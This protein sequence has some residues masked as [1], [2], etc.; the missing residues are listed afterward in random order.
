MRQLY[1]PERLGPVLAGTDAGIPILRSLSASVDNRTQVTDNVSVQYGSQ[2]DMVSFLDHLT[3][4]SPYARLSWAADDATDVEVAYSSGNARPDMVDAGADDAGLR[5]DLNSL[6]MFPRLSLADGHTRL[7][8][9]EEYEVAVAHKMGSRALR[10]SAYREML[11]DAAIAIVT[12]AGF[13]MSGNIVPDL[14]SNSSV[15]NAGNFDMTG[16]DA[17]FT[18]NLGEHVSVTVSYGN[19]DE[20]I[21][22]PHLWMGDTLLTFPWIDRALFQTAVDTRAGQKFNHLRGVLLSRPDETQRAFLSADQPNVAA[23]REIDDRVRYVNSKGI[24]ADLVLAWTPDQLVK[25]FPSWQQRERYVRYLAARYSAMHITWQLSNEFENSD[26]SRELLKEI[27]QT[28]K[29]L[30]SYQHPRSTGTLATSSPLLEDGWEDYVSYGSSEDGLGAIEHQLYTVPFV[31]LRIGSEDSGAGRSGPGDGDADAF[32]RRLWNSTMDG[33][34]PTFANTGTSGAGKLPVDAKYLDSPAAR[35]MSVWSTFFAGTRYWDLEP[36]F[37]VDGGRALALERPSGDDE[38]ELGQEQ[39]QMEGV[40]YVV[41]VEKPGPVEVTIRKQTYD[42]EWVN[43][44]NGEAVTLKRFKGDK[45]SGEPPDRSHDWVLHI[46]REGRKQSLRSYKFES[47]PVIMQEIERVPQKI[48]YE[49]A[50]PSADS[51]SLSKPASYA[52]KLDAGHQG[53][54]RDDVLVDGRGAR[55]P[56]GPPGDRHRRAGQVS[57]PPSLR[58]PIRQIWPSGFMA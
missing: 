1:L 43:P 33:Q 23:F 11:S 53:D 30:D 52:V 45:F 49:I 57:V 22:T 34:Y 16:L 28:L 46:S 31:N 51:I 3:Y 24:V 32:R 40:E 39:E 48:P 26:N 35:Q 6:G 15:F 19:E 42:V 38:D 27:G 2:V 5:E 50:E 21:K 18:Q 13:F 55:G 47:A 54:A 8:R 44:I 36:Y 12:P 10:L 25:L 37:E 20:L 14:F 4:L 29:K 58:T 41:Y 17:A 9:G 7:Q 56:A